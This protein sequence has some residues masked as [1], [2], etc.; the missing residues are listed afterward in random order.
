[1]SLLFL[2]VQLDFCQ[3]GAV[4]CSA[5]LLGVGDDLAHSSI[6][7]GNWEVSTTVEEID[8]VA[9]KMKTAVKRFP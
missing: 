3:L 4:L 9:E 5:C 1:M 8:Y 2:Q 6:R 7:L